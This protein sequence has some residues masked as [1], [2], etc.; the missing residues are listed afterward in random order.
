MSRK[1]KMPLS[2][3]CNFIVRDHSSSKL[4]AEIV[5]D[6]WKVFNWFAKRDQL[7]LPFVLYKRK[8]RVDE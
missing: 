4:C 5:E 2:I 3:E 6:W 8:I 7:S 1:Q